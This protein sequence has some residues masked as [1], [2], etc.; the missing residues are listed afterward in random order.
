MKYLF[1]ATI[2]PVQSFIAQARKLQDLYA[3]SF[4]L[5]YLTKNLLQT[6]NVLGAK[7]LYPRY[8]EARASYPNLFVA[9]VE[10]DSPEQLRRFAGELEHAVRTQFHGMADAVMAH[11]NLTPNDAF[12]AQIDSLLQFYWSAEPYASGENYRGAFL[13]TLQRMGA[14]KTT[15]TFKALSETAGRKCSLSME[16]NALFSRGRKAHLVKDAYILPRI[17][18][19]Y[20]QENETLGAVAFVKRCLDVAVPGFTGEFPD[21]ETVAHLTR[22]ANSYYALV[23]FDGD[24]MG[25]LYS[26]DK[27]KSEALEDFQ[28][29]LS[30]MAG[31]SSGQMPEIVNRK[32]KNG[33]VIYAGGDDFLGVMNLDNVFSTMQDLRALFA[34]TIQTE[35]YVGKAATFSAGIVIA[36]IR[37]PLGDALDWAR[38]AEHSAKEFKRGDAAKDAYCLTIL[39][40]NGEI[41]QCTHGFTLKGG[42]SGMAVLQGFIDAIV[43]SKVSTGFIYQLSQEFERLFKT[44]QKMNLESPQD[45]K[46]RIALHADMF[47]SEARRIIGRAE[48][49]AETDRKTV[50]SEICGYIDTFIDNSDD[51]PVEV[52]NLLR[53]IA[54]IARQRGG[55]R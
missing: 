50:L 17:D 21:I 24:D 22:E 28:K 44:H 15:R 23:R 45:E 40:H 47:K 11:W 39:R 13:K 6:A 10:K 20:L 54:F 53:A 32:N 38:R 52:L 55:A 1:R 31:A 7:I 37:A 49:P 2:G 35:K 34:K 27:V 9:T 14:A 46:G 36:H 29:A 4:L 16:Q 25:T 26:T 18:P 48:L 30:D 33:A 5:S 8:N 19:K 41:T 43:G 3:G 12:N 51:R 42:Q